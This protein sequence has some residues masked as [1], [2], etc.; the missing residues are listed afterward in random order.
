M[1]R[2]S[3]TRKAA[4]AFSRAVLEFS[5]I[6]E[7]LRGFLSGPISQPALAS[8][9]PCADL[10][11]IR[12]RLDRGREAR[13]FLRESSRP[14]LGSLQDPRAVLE[15]L[16]VAAASLTA[17]EILALLEV[18]RAACDLRGLFS[19]S[20]F[21]RLDELARGMADFRDLLKELGGKILPDGTVDSSASRELARIRRAIENLRRQLQSTLEKILG[22]LSKDQIVQ[23]AVVTLRN[24][25]F[26]IPIRAEEKRRVSGIVHG[27]SSSGATVFVE[28]LD[29]VP[30]NN[31]LVELQ[32]GEFAEAQRILAEFSE[33]LRAR[34]AELRAA[35]ETLSELDVAFAK[36]EF[37]RAYH[38]C[39]PEFVE[40]RAIL[41]EDARH[42]LL[43][44]VQRAQGREPVPLTI[45][46]A[47]PKTLMIISGPNA[48]GKTVA[49]KTAGAAV[50]MA[51]AGLP[52][53]ASQARLPV[54][55]RVLADIG[56]QQSIQAN[57]S[58][59][60]AH[61]TNI[62]AMVGVAGASDLVLLDEIGASTEPGE[63][64]ALAVA[65]LEYFRECGA[66][67]FVT[68]HHSRL[69]AYA[70]ETPEAV[71][72]AM[73]FDEAT[74]RP[75]YRLISGLPGK[76]SGLD[77]AE[78]LGLEPSIVSKARALLDPADSETAALVVS[79]HEQK[80]EMD[81]QIEN[82]ASKRKELT[83][84]RIR[85]EQQFQQERR[86]KLQEL[87]TRLEE[88]LR[89]SESKWEKML[90]DIRAQA[91]AL[92]QQASV[93]KKAERKG[94]EIKSQ[95]REDWN[96]QVLETLG[97]PAEEGSVAAAPPAVGDRVR[98]AN[99]STPGRVAALLGDRELEVEVG[100]LRMRVGIDEVRVLSPAGP[101]LARS[102]T[103]VAGPRVTI[104]RS[105]DEPAD[106][107]S[108][109]TAEIN[110]I[111]TTADEACERV[112][113][114]LDESF[115]AGKLRLRVVHGHG[116][117]I[118]RKSLREMLASHPHVERFCAAPQNEGGAGATI[119]ELKG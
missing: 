24:D 19:K 119:V 90:A 63:G 31:E 69:K 20:P 65:I 106:R 53:A 18:A 39:F 52:V 45:E 83:V 29:T 95:A 117:G 46:L 93:G 88:T 104:T 25:R 74:L 3:E 28:P 110:V 71:N 67:T 100:R 97:A 37:A 21:H 59:F 41:L 5:G 12:P 10:P 64:A 102:K 26:V 89:Q 86:A 105:G 30:L 75:T 50:L 15:K 115:L 58:T 36:A 103:A 7:V 47:E 107:S 80:A 49:L 87:D 9:E 17:H 11:Q 101:E 91:R 35:T 23:D 114:F 44:K 66:M 48:G 27:A 40:E 84:E 34:S 13:D 68:T 51:Q 2:A 108:L 60:S 61:I 42:P 99:L 94:G 81:R 116:K 1:D 111:G 57:L 118:L 92:G 98:L 62:Q 54:F 113:K 38:C 43:E 8:L 85:L 4:D 109:P 72:A 6:V 96:T 16:T 73:E 76:S 32:E 77:T 112:D 82:L 14:S 33:K 79:L 78:R 56:D 22:R 55:R 70:A